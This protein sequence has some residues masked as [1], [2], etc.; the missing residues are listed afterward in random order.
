[1]IRY[2]APPIAP[3]KGAKSMVVFPDWVVAPTPCKSVTHLQIDR[4]PHGV[5]RREVRDIL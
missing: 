5:V 4:T 2:V 3:Y 1:M